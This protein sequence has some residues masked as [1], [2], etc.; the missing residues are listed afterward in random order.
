[1]TKHFSVFIAI[2]VLLLI[3]ACAKSP[4]DARKEL[5]RLGIQYSEEAFIKSSENGDT[6]A[7]KL[8]LDTGMKRDIIT[9]ALVAASV[10]VVF[11]EV[12]PLAFYEGPCET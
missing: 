11:M 10:S 5:G 1:M 12:N 9:L 7:V 8:F 4:E 3:V 2:S 6:L